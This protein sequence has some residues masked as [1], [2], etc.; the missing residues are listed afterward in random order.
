MF[1]ELFCYYDATEGASPP[2]KGGNPQTN[3]RILFLNCSE[4]ASTLKPPLSSVPVGDAGQRRRI[5]RI[6][7]RDIYAATVAHYGRS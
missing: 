1:F 4:S 6:A 5:H 7:G 3:C 2:R